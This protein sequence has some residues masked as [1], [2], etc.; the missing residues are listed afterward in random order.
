MAELIAAMVEAIVSLF[1]SGGE[2]LGV[3][4]ILLLVFSFLLELVFWLILFA[5]ELLAALFH[6][7]KL[8][9]IRK[10]VIWRP[11]KAGRKADNGPV[12]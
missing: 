10:P 3:G 8:R 5:G 7:R 2:A 12:E 1:M 6:W 9:R 4:E 11:R